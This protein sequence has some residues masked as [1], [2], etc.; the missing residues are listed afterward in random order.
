MMTS[1]RFFVL[2]SN[3]SFAKRHFFFILIKSLEGTQ[4]CSFIGFFGKKL[5]PRP[6]PPYPLPP[7]WYRVKWVK[8]GVL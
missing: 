8:V 5:Y 6:S 1:E 3:L 4:S 7:D 2:V